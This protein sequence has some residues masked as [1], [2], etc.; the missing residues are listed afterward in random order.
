MTTAIVTPALERELVDRQAEIRE[1]AERHRAR[2]LHVYQDEDGM[3]IV[4]GRL[5]PE[6][7]ALL[8]QALAAARETVYQQGRRPVPAS[9]DV[10]AGTSSVG[11]GNEP[12]TWGQL[13]ADALTL[14]AATALHHGMDPGA[15]GER[16]P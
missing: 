14:I 13:Q 10:P 3:V 2:A 6:A 7:G 11:V 9:A 8:M 12:P 1:T 16:Y 4:R 5:E 15:G